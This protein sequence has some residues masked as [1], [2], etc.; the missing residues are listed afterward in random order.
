MQPK[1][2][3]IVFMKMKKNYGNVTTENGET[4]LNKGDILFLPY[5]NAK[6]FLEPDYSELI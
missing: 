6:V 5:Q 2:S 1:T 4:P 3:N